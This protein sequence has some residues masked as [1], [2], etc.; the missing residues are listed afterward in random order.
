[1][2]GQG[3]PVPEVDCHIL[4]TGHCLAHEHILIEGG[5]RKQVACH[6]IVALLGHP[7]KGWLMWDGG[8][9]PHM[10]TATQHFPYSLYRLATPLRLR[11]ELSAAAQ[12]PRLGLSPADVRTI[13]VSHFHAD[14]I[15]GLADFP[16]SRFVA[17]REAYGSVAH[18]RGLPALRRAFI[19]SLLPGDF[20]RRV[21]LLGPFAGPPLPPLGPTHDLYGDG[22]LLLVA[23]PGH[24]RGQTGLLANTVRG[25][26]F[27]VADSC[28]MA[29]SITLN[30]PPGAIGGLLADDTGA[31]AETI[32]RMHAFAQ[33]RPDVQIIPSHCPETFA[34]LVHGR[35][36]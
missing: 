32:A 24:A 25:P 35:N 2:S 13:V 3:R 7:Q 18:L 20:V 4:D 36:E 19:P 23:L 17:L 6:S 29:R 9:A 21:T 5:A 34:E 1:M 8:Y 16:Q 12:L 26:V 10:L 28:W 11:P 15:A 14:H 22:S 33:A 31:V 27:F 30:R